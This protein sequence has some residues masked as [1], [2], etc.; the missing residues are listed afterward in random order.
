MKAACV[1][2]Q[3]FVRELG[4]WLLHTSVTWFGCFHWLIKFSPLTSPKEKGVSLQAETAETEASH[5]NAR[6]DQRHGC[7][8]KTSGFS[9]LPPTNRMEYMMSLEKVPVPFCTSEY[10]L[11]HESPLPPNK[12][13]LFYFV[14]LKSSPNETEH[15]GTRTI[16]I[17]CS[18][19]PKHSCSI[20]PDPKPNATLILFP[21]D[22]LTPSFLVLFKLG[23]KLQ[24]SF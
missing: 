3:K 19:L 15:I 20:P 22:V 17:F 23:K 11:F 16:F 18:V 5:D 21:H 12:H 2:K 7:A 9:F 1:A 6:A 24:F 10:L 14:P 8:K 4:A 13:F